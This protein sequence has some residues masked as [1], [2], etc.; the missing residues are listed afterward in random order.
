[1]ADVLVGS[2]LRWMLRFNMIDALPSFT[3][4]AARLDER[5]AVQASEAR[6][7]AIRAELGLG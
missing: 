3:A 5:P 6:N 7:A 2:S 4:Y 1:M